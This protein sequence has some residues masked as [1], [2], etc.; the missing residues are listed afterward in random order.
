MV[1]SVLQV[2]LKQVHLKVKLDNDPPRHANIY[3]W[4]EEKA[5]QKVLA[6]KLAEQAEL[7]WAP[8]R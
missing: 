4:P 1:S 8:G 6:L 7:R 2:H 5:E 3:G